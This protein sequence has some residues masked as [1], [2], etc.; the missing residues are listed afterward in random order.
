MVDALELC[1]GGAVDE[2][3]SSS[4]SI[5][6]GL[7]GECAPPKLPEPDPCFVGAAGAVGIGVGLAVVGFLSAACEDLIACE[8]DAPALA[9]E[10][11]PEPEPIPEPAPAPEPEPKPIPDPEPAPPP[12]PEPPAPAPEPANGVY[13]PPPELADVT[14]PPPPPKK[15]A[16]EFTSPAPTAQSA[17][18]VAPVQESA[19]RVGQW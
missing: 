9:P 12:K 13:A 4:S 7:A 17:P 2:V 15:I 11:E 19:R 10:P 18:E 6:A 1:V 8:S 14:E 5:S 3:A 16:A